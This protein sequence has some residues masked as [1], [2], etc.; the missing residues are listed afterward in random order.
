[1]LFRFRPIAALGMAAIFVGGACGTT[2]CKGNSCA[3]TGT[4]GAFI[5]Q[6]SLTSPIV[7]VTAD[8][9]CS[10][11]QVPAD[12]GGEIFVDVHQSGPLTSGSCQIHATLADGS[13]WVAMF[14]WTPVNSVCCGSSIGGVGPA[15]MFTR[16]S[17]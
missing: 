2:G 1:M 8:A 6:S 15:P 9:P 11:T 12:G 7:T 10:V 17:P 5:D 3:G 14:S 13:T 4:A 16:S